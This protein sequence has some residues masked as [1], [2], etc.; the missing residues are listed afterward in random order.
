MVLADFGSLGVVGEKH[1]GG[2]FGTDGF[3]APYADIRSRTQKNSTDLDMYSL[4]ATI[5]WL[6]GAVGPL[7][8]CIATK[9][10]D[11]DLKDLKEKSPVFEE[12]RRR[13]VDQHIPKAR[14]P[15]AHAFVSRVSRHSQCGMALLLTIFLSVSLSRGQ[16]ASV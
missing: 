7:S 11:F 2:N 1:D 14:H 13:T 6:A 15:Q 5:L 12:V 4:G 9:F 16:G 10:A 3:V 8:C